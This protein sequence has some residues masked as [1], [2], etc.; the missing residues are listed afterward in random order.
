[1]NVIPAQGYD[2]TFL[3]PTIAFPELRINAQ[4]DAYQVSNSPYIHYMHFSLTL[5]TSK[6]FAYW[7]AW[8]IDGSHLNKNVK[9]TGKSFRKDKRIPR[10]YQ[11]GA[12]LYSDNILDRGH[13]ARHEDLLWGNDDEAEQASYDSFFYTNITPQA[14]GFNQSGKKG[15]WGQLENA[16]L[17]VS[18]N[19]RMS[20]FAGPIFQSRD[21]VYERQ[22]KFQ[23]PS[24][25]FKILAYQNESKL[26]TKAFILVQNLDRLAISPL[27]KFK[28]FEHS[29]SEIESFRLLTFPTILK[30]TQK[31]SRRLSLLAT[32]EPIRSVNEIDW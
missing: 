29:I 31:L 14:K 22:R 4:A 17:E 26:T 23:I 25:F 11:A 28:T 12:E 32:N 2:P 7:A 21:R 19:K 3:G 20:C 1:M 9:R 10:E 30:D 15:V 13:L 24:K 16:A 18:K 8:N 27:D 5:S 6:Q